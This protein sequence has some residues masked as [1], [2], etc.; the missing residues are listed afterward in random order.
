MGSHHY[1]QMSEEEDPD[2]SLLE[3]VRLIMPTGASV[4]SVCT[5]KLKRKFSKCPLFVNLYGQTEAG[6]VVLGN[7]EMVG[8]GPI[9]PGC[10]IKVNIFNHP[11]LN[12]SLLSS[13]DF[14]VC[15][16][17]EWRALPA[18]GERGDAVQD[19]YNV[20]GLLE[21]AQISTL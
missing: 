10:T 8:L 16:C 21:P 20:H 12:C 1:V 4:P 18:Y 5:E 13:G 2:P 7:Q 14:A 3:S 17:R 19:K 6:T 15:E 11:F 9:K